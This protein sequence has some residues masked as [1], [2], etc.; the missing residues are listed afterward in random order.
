[1]TES[2]FISTLLIIEVIFSV[3]LLKLLKKSGGS[4]T[5]I[6]LLAS[7][8]TAWLVSVYMM[9]TNG[10]FSATGM[11][12]VAFTLGVVVP[13]VLGLVAAKF[14]KPLSATIKNMAVSDFLALQHMRAA[15]GAMFF[16]TA[17]LPVWFQYLGGLGDIAA[18]VGAFFALRYLA[19]N[20]SKQR[21]ANIRGNLV[22]ILDFFIVLNVGV[23]VVLDGHSPDMTFNLIPLYAV[24][25]F[26]LL[27]IFSLQKLRTAGSD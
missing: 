12:Q 9:L 10:F 20:P 5:L 4:N 19:R 1:M 7:I 6:G 13:V 17:S 26:I 3:M 27:H 14:Y 2:V 24:P 15:F 18:G 23:M 11:P 16:L 25:L 22:G 8:F 21:R